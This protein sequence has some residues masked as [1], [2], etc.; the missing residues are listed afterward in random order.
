[1]VGIIMIMT[2]ATR[3]MLSVAARGLERGGA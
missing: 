3:L 1:L 2:G